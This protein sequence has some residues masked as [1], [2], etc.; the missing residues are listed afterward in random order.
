MLDDQR[1]GSIKGTKNRA[2]GKSTGQGMYRR[3]H[4]KQGHDLQQVVLD[5]ISDDAILI[6]VAAPALCAKVFTEN[7]LYIPDEAAAP[8]GL[9]YQVG[10]S[11]DLQDDTRHASVRTVVFQTYAA[12][13]QHLFM[14]S[15]L[16]PL[17]FV[18][19]E[20]CRL[21][22]AL[23]AACHSRKGMLQRCAR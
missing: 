16:M 1:V 10:K 22:C 15:S 6:K 14:D 18:L 20:C 13:M 7:D 2:G 11:Q 5:D 19:S 12:P 9:K 23:L 17:M 21:C 8:Q 4:G 3:L